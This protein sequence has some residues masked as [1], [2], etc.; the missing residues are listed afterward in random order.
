MIV[1][2]LAG[3]AGCGKDTVAN[4]L[5]ERHGFVRFAF[6]D[7]LYREV[8]EAYGLPDETLLRDRTAKEEPTDV[9]RLDQCSD[10]GFVRCARPLVADL[11]PATFGDLDKYP[12]SPREVL[13][14]WGTDYRRAQDQDYWISRAEE[15]IEC[16][17]AS[18][19]YPEFAPQ[20]FV[21][22]GTRFENERGF[23]KG[24]VLAPWLGNIWHIHRGDDADV[25]NHVSTN[26][27]PVLPGERELW[28]NDSIERLYKGVDLLLSTT[29]RFVRVEP[30]QPMEEQAAVP[31]G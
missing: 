17:V 30:M 2:G 13:Q 25:N 12:L 1:I 7:A 21:E 23:I 31:Q 22:A 10:G 6:S 19:P 27:L 26:K 3:P 24:S 18:A 14:W 28:N 20:Y 8:A 15:F 4:Y 11:Y 16:T 5:V 29:A 9:L